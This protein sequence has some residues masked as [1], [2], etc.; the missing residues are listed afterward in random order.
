MTSNRDS[1]A[2]KEDEI[3]AS[4]VSG[5]R[6]SS[7]PPAAEPDLELRC[8]TIDKLRRL[9][10]RHFQPGSMVLPVEA[11]RTRGDGYAVVHLPNGKD[12]WLRCN[13][14]EVR[15]PSGPVLRVRFEPLTERQR[16]R[17]A[18]AAGRKPSTG[19][20]PKSAE[21]PQ[22]GPRPRGG[23]EP[24]EPKPSTGVRTR[25]GEARATQPARRAVETEPFGPDPSSQPPSGP[26]SYRVP[27]SSLRRQSERA[28]GEQQQ[29][30]ALSERKTEP[31]LGAKEGS[32]RPPPNVPGSDKAA[33]R[34][35]RTTDPLRAG[36]MSSG[37]SPPETLE[38]KLERNE[39]VRRLA[40]QA[41]HLREV[42]LSKEYIKTLK[43]ILEISPNHPKVLAALAEAE[44][45]ESGTEAPP[46]ADP[47]RDSL[48]GRLFRKKD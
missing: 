20:R 44:A 45:P 37:S 25:G 34:R 23:V 11:T 40:D 29:S 16:R 43:R 17:V 13:L 5:E 27:R 21:K 12:L 19:V 41:K 18:E 47:P 9:D 24:P 1:T 36:S 22:T 48:F 3:D 26:V 2:D 28:P 14:A 46:P 39:K 42:G 32:V 31:A 4:D 38:S 35:S 7:R 8:E 33:Q 6:P 30:S 15:S 10:E